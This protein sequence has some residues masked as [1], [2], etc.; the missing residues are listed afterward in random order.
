MPERV[1]MTRDRLWRRNHP[2]AVIVDRRTKWGN[3]FRLRSRDA[4]ARVPAVH[5]SDREW[6]HE[7]RISADGMEHAYWHPD[8]RVIPC[9][10]RCMTAA[11]TVECY[12]AYV[13]GGGWPL[14]G[15]MTTLGAPTVA[16]IR[17]ELAGRDLAC[18]CR[19][20]QP[21][22]ADVLLDIAN[23]EPDQRLSDS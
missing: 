4:L 2:D 11:E 3:P 23:Q 21:C 9:R 19:L 5:H 22:H 10:I 20:S 13:T 12:R 17:A 7:S 15:W 14:E 16:E 1:Q 6:E 8:G 18:W